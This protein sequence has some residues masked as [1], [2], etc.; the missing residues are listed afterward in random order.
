M[1]IQNPRRFDSP[2][3]TQ[4]HDTLVEARP[5]PQPVAP[6]SEARAPPVRA[7]PPSDGDSDGED[8]AEAPARAPPRPAVPPSA[9]DTSDDAKRKLTALLIDSGRAYDLQAL[10]RHR[11]AVKAEKAKAE[12]AATEKIEI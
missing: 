6:P 1:F 10:D 2:E 3:P 8:A 12:E 4:L 9:G 7:P 5:A 11:A